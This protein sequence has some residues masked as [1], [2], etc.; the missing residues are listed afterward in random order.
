MADANKWAQHARLIALSKEAHSQEE[1]HEEFTDEAQERRRN[2]ANKPYYPRS[3]YFN[4][5]ATKDGI[6]H[7]AHGIGDSNPLFTDEEYAK[8]SKY[9]NI[10]APGAYLYSVNWINMGYGGPGV[11][12]WYSGGDWEWYKPVS[13]GDEFTVIGIFRDLVPKKGK[14]GAGR[15]WIDYGDVIYIN[16]KGEI[17]AKECQHIVLGERARASSAKQF[18]HIPKPEYSKEDWIKILDLYEQ[19]EVRGSEPR[20][21]EDVEVDGKVG[22]MIKGPLSVRDIIAWL[23]GGGTPYIRAHKIEYEY[24]KRHPH[25]LEYVDTGEADNPGDVPE[26][27]H[28]LAPFAKTIG[29]ERIY[30][31]GNQ[32]MSWL[33]N[34][35]TNWMGDDGFLWKMSGDLRTFNLAGDITNFEGKVIKKYKEGDFCCVD[36]E[37]WAKNQRDQWSITP[38]VST[39]ILPSKEHGAVV[40]PDPP[41]GLDEEVKNARPLNELISDGLIE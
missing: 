38:H 31:Y 30:D 37:A 8:K 34:L 25:T 6:R 24:E 13:A 36:I 2:R 39:V 14:M 28:I 12:G 23:M 17:V 32:R 40:Y 27:V 22:P 1:K 41:A 5:Q 16:Q 19:E 20:Y 9:G 26:L 11:H 18:R 15:T 35:F 10:V 29:I 33:C 7:F 3:V 4:S 21:W